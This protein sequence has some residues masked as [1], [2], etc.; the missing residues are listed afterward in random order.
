MN[1]FQVVVLGIV[2]GL[3]EFMPVSSSG[4]LVLVPWWLGWPIP[5]VAFDAILHLGTVLAVLVVFYRDLWDIVVAW[6]RSLVGRGSTAESRLGWLLILATIPAAVAGLKLE[7]FFG[8]LFG[9]PLAV[10]CL[11]L[12]TG[13]FLAL[14]EFF[15]EREKTLTQM[16][17]V[18]ALI[19]G[20]AQAAAIAPGISRSGAT[21]SAGLLR[22]F[23][24]EEAA[25]FS[26]I[27]SIPVILGAGLSQVARMAL[28]PNLP[29]QTEPASLLI[30][31]F[32]AAA[33]TGYLTIRFLLRYLQRGS[34]YPFAIYCWIVGGISVIVVLLS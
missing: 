32:L 26:F 3:A 20:L 19:V 27:L 28:H 33:V 6:L 11:L 25:R 7:N 14:A 10:A 5:G 18:D 16:R 31:G 30:V 22:G 4:H 29:Q 8:K 15:S 12:V 24:R 2:Q 13:C 1:I 34:L 17:W 23:K 9:S 21:I